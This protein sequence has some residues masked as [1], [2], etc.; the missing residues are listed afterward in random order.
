MNQKPSFGHTF[1]F[2]AWISHHKRDF[3]YCIPSRDSSEDLAK[4]QWNNPLV[5]WTICELKWK[6]YIGTVER[7]NSSWK[8]HLNFQC[9]LPRTDKCGFETF[10]I[11][12]PE[13]LN[14]FLKVCRPVWIV[15]SAKRIKILTEPK[16]NMYYSVVNTVLANNLTPYGVNIYIGTLK[17]K[18]ESHT[19]VW[20]NHSTRRGMVSIDSCSAP[21][22][23]LSRY[24]LNCDLGT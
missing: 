5:L 4:R 15:W 10:P 1:K 11:V 9:M 20:R 21:S 14:D 12:I 6:D 23:C 2:S 18:V 16:E 19:R 13:W 22:H 24:W 7:P 8:L 17:T 3:W